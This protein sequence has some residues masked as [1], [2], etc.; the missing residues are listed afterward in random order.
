MVFYLRVLFD[1][2]LVDE[3]VRSCRGLLWA[4]YC[5][6]GFSTAAA[7]GLQAGFYPVCR[8]WPAPEPSRLLDA[9]AAEAAD[10][11]RAVDDCFFNPAGAD[12]Y[13]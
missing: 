8:F 12:F 9:V 11:F 3:I 1:C 10:L 6:A 4:G 7:E 5:Y 13:S 2:V